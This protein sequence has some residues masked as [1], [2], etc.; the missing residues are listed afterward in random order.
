MEQAGRSNAP[1][2]LRQ[3]RNLP[4]KKLPLQRAF[5]WDASLCLGDS[6]PTGTVQAGLT[7]GAQY[8]PTWF[9]MT[10]LFQMSPAGGGVCKHE[11]GKGVEFIPLCLPDMPWQAGR[12]CP[13]KQSRVQGVESYM[14]QI[15]SKSKKTEKINF[16]PLL[17]A[18]PSHPPPAGDRLPL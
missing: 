10:M 16:H 11:G 13:D 7:A 2:Y 5:S 4:E 18:R 9:E 3:K 1:A 14:S 6:C 8:R 12:A 15:Q 17:P